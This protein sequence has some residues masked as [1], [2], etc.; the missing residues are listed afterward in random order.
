MLNIVG[1]LRLLDVIRSAGYCVFKA[2]QSVVCYLEQW[3]TLL[4]HA[5][6]IVPSIR[7]LSAEHLPS[8]SSIRRKWSKVKHITPSA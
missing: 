6:P 3:S 8:H 5:E 4:S 7:S 2:S 1:E